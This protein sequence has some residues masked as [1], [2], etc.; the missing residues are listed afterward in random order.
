MP[1]RLHL[2]GLGV[3][4]GEHATLEVLQAAG[5]CDVLFCSGLDA[6]SRRFLS[7]FAA[8]GARIVALGEGD[9]EEAAFRKVAAAL[10]AGKTAA[11]VTPGHPYYWSALAGR[12]AVEAGKKGVECATFGA[13]SP[14]GLALAASGVTLGMN[15]HG[16]QAFEA[17]ALVERKG[18][19]NLSWP[20]A[21]YFYSGADRK[22][23]SALVARLTREYGA[24]HP[25]VWCRAG[26]A[27]SV[28]RVGDLA[29][30]LK[31]LGPSRVL[32]LEPKLESTSTIGRTDFHPMKRDDKKAPAWV[33]Q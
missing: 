18:R 16:L 23:F 1:N 15:V 25:A 30:A 21:V 11:L 12:L 31:D 17:R 10:A 24:D 29:A 8:K 3:E 33:K 13:V 6:K 20:L 2:L 14:L 27:R 7:R 19:L 28:G 26:A 9:G 4:P 5:E 32:F 22:T